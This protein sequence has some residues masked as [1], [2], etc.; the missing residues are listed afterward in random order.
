MLRHLE[1][2]AIPA[3][4]AGRVRLA[5]Q[6]Q[7]RGEARQRLATRTALIVYQQAGGIAMRSARAPQL[8]EL[9]RK[10]RHVQR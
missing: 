8:Y 10:P 7:L 1:H 5:A 4:A 2:A 3:L 6:R 9:R